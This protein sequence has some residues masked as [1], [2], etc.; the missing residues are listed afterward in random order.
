[1]NATLNNYFMSSTG[2]YFVAKTPEVFTNDADG[3]LLSDGRFTYD[4]NAEN[5]LTQVTTP[6]N[7]PSLLP[8]V[9]VKSS[10]D[11]QGRRIA[12][13][14]QD[15]NGTDWPLRETRRFIYDGWN[16]VGE[17]R[18]VTNGTASTNWYVWGLDLSGSIQ[19]AGGVGGLMFAQFPGNSKNYYAFDG[20]GNVSELVGVNG[21]VRAHYEYDPFGNS[22]T[23]SGTL[24]LTN[25]FRFSTKYWDTDTKLAYYGFR[26]YSPGLGRWL[27][28]DPLG[29]EGGDNIVAFCNND[30]NNTYD[31]LGLK[32]GH[33]YEFVINQFI[34]Q[35]TWKRQTY[36]RTVIFNY[37]GEVVKLT[38]E[39]I[40]AL[41]Y[42][43][44]I[45]E[46]TAVGFSCIC[47]DRNEYKPEFSLS[48]MSQIY[49]LEEDH[50][51]WKDNTR[52]G[53][54]DEHIELH[55]P[56][57]SLFYRRHLVMNHE[58]AHR[59][60]DRELSDA[61]DKELLEFE[62]KLF[63]SRETCKEAARN[64]VLNSYKNFHAKQVDTGILIDDGKY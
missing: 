25:P 52:P 46:P 36:Q 34:S 11:H 8:R 43:L 49:L 47:V 42:G 56:S 18:T 55:W 38:H 58:R 40:K 4:W 7:L 26:Y 50:R 14:I 33:F 2:R 16:L 9:K 13:T 29:A 61:W 39:V 3:N 17:T 24:A 6:G 63:I 45:T 51:K 54:G 60:K 32:S 57:Y 15:Y 44:T 64:K 12:Q 27:S 22:T 31:Y 21:Q 28:F 10:Y 37:D 35:N 30:Q 41:V 1:M 62:T 53:T 23:E 5:R 20:N 59:K 48:V 19:G